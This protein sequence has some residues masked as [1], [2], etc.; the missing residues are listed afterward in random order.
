MGVHG[1]LSAKPNNPPYG[2]Y[3][4]WTNSAVLKQSLSAGVDMR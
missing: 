1:Q 2:W 4:K 3:G